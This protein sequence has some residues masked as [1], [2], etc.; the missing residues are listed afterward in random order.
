[1]GLV[2]HSWVQEARHAAWSRGVSE[3]VYWPSQKRLVGALVRESEVR[4]ACAPDEPDHLYGYIVSAGELLHWVYVKS[5]FRNIGIAKG[6]FEAAGEPKRASMA[7]RFLRDHPDVVARHGITYDPFILL[8][9]EL[10]T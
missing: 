3:D 7:S 2:K 10:R 1:M 4:V 8:R 5:A 9:E 6:L